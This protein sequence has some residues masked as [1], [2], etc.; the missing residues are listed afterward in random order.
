MGQSTNAILFYGYCW[1]KETSRPWE[2]GH[3]NEDNE[4]N[5]DENDDENANE[6]KADWKERYARTKGCLPPSTPFPA[7]EVKPTRENGWS[8]TPKDY[9]AA[10][11]AIIDQHKAYW[12][13][14][15]K[16]VEASAC[17]VDTHCSGEC[18]M[19]YVAVKASRTI[20]YRGDMHEIV[21]LIVDPIWDA[22]LAEF[23][24]AMGIKTEGKKAAWWLVSDWN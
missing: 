18:P 15:Q 13:A 2:I 5:A 7:R 16:I 22:A 17:C 21:T 11:Q 19:P 12:D 9:S 6:A 24:T 1:D 3:N 23:C 10:E 8:S 14:K 4:D 20:S